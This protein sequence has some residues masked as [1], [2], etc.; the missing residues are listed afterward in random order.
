MEESS[1]LYNEKIWYSITGI[2]WLYWCSWI[3][4]SQAWVGT[5]S[6][7]SRRLLLHQLSHYISKCYQCFG[8]SVSLCRALGCHLPP[9]LTLLLNE[10]S[11]NVVY[12]KIYTLLLSYAFILWCHFHVKLYL[13][14]DH[15]I[16]FRLLLGNFSVTFLSPN[17]MY[18]QW[19]IDTSLI[20]DVLYYQD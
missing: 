13:E 15:M 4:S 16:A 14:Y 5:D 20:I 8:W 9:N 17:S 7:P 1:S 19:Y 2:T 3:A 11:H 10:I 12:G 6:S 18:E